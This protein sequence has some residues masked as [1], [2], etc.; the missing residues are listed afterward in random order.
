[1]GDKTY[2]VI[3]YD[4]DFPNV[5]ILTQISG[6]QIAGLIR[7]MRQSSTN[8]TLLASDGGIIATTSGVS[9]SLSAYSSAQD[10]LPYN[11]KNASSGAI[12]IGTS[13]G[14][15]IQT[16]TGNV[17]SFSLPSDCSLQLIRNASN[18]VN[19]IIQ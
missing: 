13:S 4:A 7:A 16:A 14:E 1:M 8:D 6:T 2:L 10:G 9:I 12:T 11:L 3:C 19:W 5:P 15:F 18:T 17:T